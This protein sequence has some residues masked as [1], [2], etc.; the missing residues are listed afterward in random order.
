MVHLCTLVGVHDCGV[1]IRSVTEQ[2]RNPFKSRF[3]EYQCFLRLMLKAPFVFLCG[4]VR[5]LRGPTDS[6]QTHAFLYNAVFLVFFFVGLQFTYLDSIMLFRR[7]GDKF[8]TPSLWKTYTS[9]EL[10]LIIPIIISILGCIAYQ[11]YLIVLFGLVIWYAV[12]YGIVLFVLIVPTVIL[13]K[14]YYLHMHHYAIFGLLIPFFAFPNFFSLSWLGVVSGV[15]V[16]GISRWGM[17]KWWYPG[18]QRVLKK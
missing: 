16:E 18:A 3:D 7:A 11:L 2:R 8:G 5:S 12:F 13:R 10:A 15:Y 9:T 4:P 14:T 6:D 1:L 17:A